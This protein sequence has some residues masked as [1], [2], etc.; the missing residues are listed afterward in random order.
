MKKFNQQNFDLAMIKN[1]E[2]C[3]S[4]LYNFDRA[5]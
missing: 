3:N 5:T 4:I 1:F 2:F